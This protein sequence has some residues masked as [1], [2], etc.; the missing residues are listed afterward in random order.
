MRIASPQRLMRR[1]FHANRDCDAV[2][3]PSS[4]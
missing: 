1:L 4:T 2:S 3:R